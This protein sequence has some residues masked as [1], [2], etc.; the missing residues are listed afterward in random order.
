VRYK[1]SIWLL[2]GIIAAICGASIL[3]VV[4]YRSRHFTPAMMLRRLP[5]HDALV[6]YVDFRELRRAG[7]L[8]M[9]DASKVAEEPEYQAFVRRTEF[10]Y[11]QDLDAAMLA[12]A[13]TGK[14]LLLE[15]RFDWKSLRAYVESERGNCYNT[16]CKLGGSAADRN[17]SFFPLR[18]TVMAMAVSPDDSAALRLQSDDPGP[19][20]DVP[21]APVWLSIPSAILKARDQL[22]GGTRMFARSVESA[23]RMTIAL[24][25]EGDRLAATLDVRCRSEQEA[26]AIAAQLSQTT[27]LLREAIARE[28]QQPNPGDLSGVLTSGTFRS[29]GTRV[30]GHWPIQRSFLQGILSGT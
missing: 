7:V 17:I 29:Q 10:N 6:V 11:R 26:S 21:Q 30:Y 13:P 14:Y 19:A 23:E 4:W 24:G 2:T 25:A 5:A 9:L 18:P 15:G 22:P 1:P 3:G 16:L 28:R 8:Q 20:G 27:R 12:L